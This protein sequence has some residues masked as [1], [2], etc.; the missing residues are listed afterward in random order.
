MHIYRAQ[1]KIKAITIPDIIPMF[2]ASPRIADPVSFYSEVAFFPPTTIDNVNDHP[3]VKASKNKF[4][5]TR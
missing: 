4:R 3:F 1:I 5:Y 2:I